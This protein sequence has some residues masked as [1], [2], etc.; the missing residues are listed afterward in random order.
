MAYVIGLGQRL[1]AGN[2]VQ[3]T[4]H[5]R[6][7]CVLDVV[8]GQA[9]LVPEV[10]VPIRVEVDENGRQVFLAKSEAYHVTG[11]DMREQ[12]K[13]IRIGDT[14]R[15]RGIRAR[16]GKVVSLSGNG[17]LRVKWNDDSVGTI[18]RASDVDLVDLGPSSGPE[19]SLPE[20]RVGD[21]V[22]HNRKVAEDHRRLGGVVQSMAPT[23]KTVYVKWDGLHDKREELVVQLELLHRSG[24]TDQTPAGVRKAVKIL[25]AESERITEQ[26]EKLQM[27]LQS[28]TEAKRI[29]LEATS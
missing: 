15:A 26:V 1:T 16:K 9:T 23:D 4:P 2:I 29:L 27:Q 5:S 13:D 6:T 7:Y 12:V 21:R 14:V 24:V 8:D 3:Q 19:E 22:R 20:I 28:I 17:W 10:G 25:D 11:R 18:I